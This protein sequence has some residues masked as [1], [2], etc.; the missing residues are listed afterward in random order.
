MSVPSR[1]A[2]AARAWSGDPPL[3]GAARE[4]L[5]E[6]AA[7]CAARGGLAGLSM[8]A[9]AEEAGVSR[10]TVYRYF[11]DRRALLE[12]TLFYAGRS[13][14]GALGEQLRRHATPA[15][16]AV[17]AMLF[18]RAEIL[19]DPVLGAL[20]SA[21]VLDAFSVAGITRR[22]A[23]DWSRHALKDLVQAA[24][25]GREEADEAVET[26]LRMLLAL[27]AAPEPRR[28]EAELRGFLARRLLPALGLAAPAVP[29]ASRKR[30]PRR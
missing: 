6:A 20:W 14:A 28:D 17:E 12:A 29:P 25:W 22:S 26:M 7:R 3:A 23:V 11:A 4:R 2:D 27:L 13:L 24:G 8:A 9:V 1:R 21:T 10:P 15:E 5:L 18:A 19:R 30:A 16:Q